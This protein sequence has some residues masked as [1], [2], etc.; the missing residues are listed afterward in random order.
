MN[1]EKEKWK[2]GKRFVY[3]ITYDEGFAELWEHTIPIHE[4]F[5]FPGH[6][7]VVVG[8][9]GELRNVAESSWNGKLHMNA[10]QI[11]ALV[12]RGWGVSSH[13]MTHGARRSMYT[14]TYSEVVESRIRLEELVGIPITSFIV[15]YDNENHP[16]VIDIA[17]NGGYLCIYTL[18]DALNDYQ[19]DLF[20]LRRSPLVE[21]GFYP[22][23]S[24]IDHYYRLHEAYEK[25]GWIVDYTHLTNPVVHSP[26]KEISQQSL[27]RR[28]EKILQVGGDEVWTANGDEVVD[29]MLVN[30]GTVIEDLGQTDSVHQWRLKVSVSGLVTRRQL[31]LSLDCQGHR[32]PSKPTVLVDPPNAL[33]HLETRRHKY[34]F[35]V[36]T[37]NGMTI[38]VPTS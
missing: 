31:T 19:T 38:S 34:M 12:A 2:F 11:K 26:Q 24:H 7:A 1:I 29:Y 33:I 23:Y 8:Q 17:R 15:P 9:I 32:V 14:N 25:R 3:T 13:S 30:Q 16:P 37:V 36:N 18:T 6:L 28:F 22:F 21:E 27:I 10:N 35:T 4:R 5:G 20:N